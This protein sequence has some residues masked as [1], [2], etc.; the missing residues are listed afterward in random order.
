MMRTFIVLGVL[1]MVTPA[2]ALPTIVNGDF[3]N[4]TTGWTAYG[5][6]WGINEAR[7]YD[8]IGAFPADL[9]NAPYASVTFWSNMGHSGQ[10]SGGRYQVVDVTGFVGQQLTLEFLAHWH[11]HGQSFA[12]HEWGVIDGTHNNPN[13]FGGATVWLF[14]REAPANG[15]PSDDWQQH[16]V[17]F[18][19]TQSTV[20]VFYKGG[21]NTGDASITRVDNFAIVPEPATLALLGLGALPLLRRRRA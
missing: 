9:G 18:T 5:S 11:N 15:N 6:G 7:S 16:S 13:D 2:F 3:S 10:G 4:G 17:D 19:P 1:A 20:T 14:K 21:T 8:D 12:W